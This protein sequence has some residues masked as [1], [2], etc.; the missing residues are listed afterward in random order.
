MATEE[1]LLVEEPKSY[2]KEDILAFFG[3]PPAPDKALEK[4]IKAKRQFW[5]KR[6]NGV[7]GRAQAEAIK[8][9]IQKLSKLLE[10]G[11][12]PDQPIVHTADGSF[13]VVGDPKSAAELA[14]QLEMFLRQR[15]WQNVFQVARKALETWPDD[16]E[17]L[18]YVA[19]ALSELLRDV[20]GL[21]DDV[22]LW[23]D[24]ATTAALEAAP[25]QPQAWLA[26]ARYALAVG[27]LPEVDSLESRAAAVGV[28]LPT[29]AYGIVATSA[30]RAGNT[31]VGIRQLIK[32]VTVSGGDPAVRSV[33]TDAMIAEVILPLLPIGD[34]KMAAAY[35]EAVA[36]AAWIAMGVPESEAELIPYRI[37]AQQA[38]GGVFIG[39]L[40][41]KPFLG[42]LTGFLALPLYAKAASRPGWRVLRD[43]P[44]DKKTWRQWLMIADGHYVE[45][46]HAAARGRFF[47]QEA[48]GARWPNQQ[49][50]E[51]LISSGQLTVNGKP[52]VKK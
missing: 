2:A 37:W 45:S 21:S 41:L 49:Q 50:V 12:F 23:A 3:I 5:G 38:S 17:V 22:V 18:L 7:G 36:V 35:V 24:R 4:N 52:Y 31:D 33:A 6:A 28:A 16:E 48:P 26:R 29:E 13:V 32:Q 25:R 27:M 42:V 51:A 40:A 43:G 46:V 34:K 19:L 39:D 30:F 9:W 1:Y 15:D 11:E 10:D 14:D 8:T 20:S 44:T 47:W